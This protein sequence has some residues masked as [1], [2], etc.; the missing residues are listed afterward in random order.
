MKKATPP[1][2]ARRGQPSLLIAIGLGLVLLLGAC[3][4]QP[5]DATED[6]VLSGNLEVTDAQLGFK[7]GGRVIARS[8]SEGDHVITGQPVARLDAAEQQSQLA[9]RR[10]EL[11]GAEAALAELE[12]GSRPQEIA[13]IAA[14]LH[15]A[16]AERDRVRLDFTRQQEL[17]AK[18]VISDRE[19]EGMQAQ[20]K[21]A[22]ARVVEATERLKLI[23]EGPRSET[24]QQ[25]R[26]RM[27]QARAAVDLAT[28][29]LDNT[30]LASPLTG[31]VLSHNIEPGEFVSPGTPVITVADTAHI[32]V[33][34]YLN[35]TDLGRVHH[36]Q[37][38]VVHTDSFP[39]RDFAGTV[40]FIAS[41]AEFTPKTVQTPK[42]RVKLVFRLKIDVANP[43]EELKP[44]MPADV[45][46]SANP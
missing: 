26:A 30:L 11:A 39:G 44:G 3:S 29:Q 12:A 43:Q 1:D 35:E 4:R 6:L 28:T 33:R 19:F 46:I 15:S 45:I 7:T 41:E 22:E 24:I 5:Q 38:V 18:E 27:A 16:E 23:Q 25:A 40:A 42:E 36:G 13:A 10:A 37:H 32:W 14:A 34:A 8:V 9:L 20:L 17:R 21:V 31:I 2:R